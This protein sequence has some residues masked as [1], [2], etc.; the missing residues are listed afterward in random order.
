MTPVACRR[1]DVKGNTKDASRE[2]KLP[3]A[4]TGFLPHLSASFPAKK[5]HSIPTNPETD[6]I[7]PV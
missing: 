2:D 4:I 7:T 6:K 1:L 5:L 3:I